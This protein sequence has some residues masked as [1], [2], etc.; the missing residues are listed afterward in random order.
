[1]KKNN[2]RRLT[3]ITEEEEVETES[4]QRFY[5]IKKKRN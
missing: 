4:A 3:A 5:S 1:M 2:M